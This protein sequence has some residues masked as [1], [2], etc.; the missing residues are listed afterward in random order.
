M[1]AVCAVRICPLP[2]NAAVSP[3]PVNEASVPFG[4]TPSSRPSA[5]LTLRLPL[6][7][8]VTSPE[9]IGLRLIPFK[10]VRAPLMSCTTEVDPAAVSVAFPVGVREATAVGG[11]L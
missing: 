6:A 3:R 7:R 10:F 8:V 1:F 2:R 11:K 5:V 9:G 4:R